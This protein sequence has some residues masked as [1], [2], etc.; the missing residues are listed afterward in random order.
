MKTTNKKQVAMSKEQRQKLFSELDSVFLPEQPRHS[1]GEPDD[2]WNTRQYTDYYNRIIKEL[3]FPAINKAGDPSCVA[4]HRNEDGGIYL[5][6]HCGSGFIELPIGGCCYY[7]SQIELAKLI[8]KV[9]PSHNDLI[10]FLN[11]VVNSDQ[12]NTSEW[13]DLKGMARHILNQS[14]QQ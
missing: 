9:V 5:E 6:L 10:G 1:Q 2:K 3:N 11:R 4:K 12:P 7:M 13:N 14:K 8:V